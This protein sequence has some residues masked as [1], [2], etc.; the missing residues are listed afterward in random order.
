MMMMPERKSCSG[1]V[2]AGI[3]IRTNNRLEM[4]ADDS[5]LRGLWER[6]KDERLADRIP[7]KAAGSPVYG[8][9]S[10]Y[11]SG[12]EGDYSVLAGVEVSDERNVPDDYATL[13]LEAGEYLVFEAHGPMPEAA[14]EV[15]GAAWNYFER[16]EA[17]ERAF[18][19]DFEV[20]HPAANTVAL[21]VGVK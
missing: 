8:V 11:E 17:P 16:E 6:F 7:D 14:A 20:Y 2:V 3:Q 18:A 1:K 13:I 4:E 5:R 9:Y 19:T 21:Y 12:T 15:W 10:E